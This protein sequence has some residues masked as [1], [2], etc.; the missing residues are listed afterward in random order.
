MQ[1]NVKC[2]ESEH[3]INSFIIYLVKTIFK[4]S[5]VFFCKV[6]QKQNGISGFRTIDIEI[7]QSLAS[8]TSIP[9]P[10]RSHSI[11]FIGHAT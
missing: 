11:R 2:N 9:F 4:I 10:L 8:L 3:K 7:R 6:Y 5:W 1:C